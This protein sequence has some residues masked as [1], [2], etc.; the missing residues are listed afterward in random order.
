MPFSN[1]FFAVAHREV[2]KPPVFCFP[3]YFVRVCHAPS[4]WSSPELCLD[5]CMHQGSVHD[6]H[7]EDVRKAFEVTYW[8]RHMFTDVLSILTVHPGRA[9]NLICAGATLNSACTNTTAGPTCCPQTNFFCDVNGAQG[10]KNVCRYAPG[11]SCPLGSKNLAPGDPNR[12][13]MFQ[14]NA[15]NVV[16]TYCVPPN[17]PN[18]ALGQSCQADC[19]STCANLCLALC[20]YQGAAP[21]DCSNGSPGPQCTQPGWNGPC[22]ACLKWV[23]G[24]EE[25]RRGG[26]VL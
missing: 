12:F 24:L 7:C 8:K 6:E 20:G 18:T 3:S 15:S 10:A 14:T 19:G 2:S 26:G 13:C 9:H 5:S 4:L 1:L 22:C 17:A 16:P 25:A 11:P 23:M 21:S